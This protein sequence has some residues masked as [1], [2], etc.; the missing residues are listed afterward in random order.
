MTRL[1]AADSLPETGP[2]FVRGLALAYYGAALLLVGLLVRHAA[3]R[4]P[5]LAEVWRSGIAALALSSLLIAFA[6]LAGVWV[7]ARARVRS[8][9]TVG[10]TARLAQAVV[11]APLAGIASVLCWTWRLP[12]IMPIAPP[13]V[14]FAIGG[15]AI[16]LAFPL[17]IAER[18]VA[19]Q[20]DSVLPEAAALRALLLAPVLAWPLLGAL[21]IATGLGL[22]YTATATR[23]LA[24]VL[25]LIAAELAARALLRLFL[26]PP[27]PETARAAVRSTL[28]GIL[29]ASA[30][31]DGLAAPIRAHLG[32]D[33]ARSW[34]L[35]YVRAALPAVALLLL[36]LAWGLSGV[37]LVG[38]DQRAVYERFGAPVA[39]L[40]P[41]AHLILPWP[42]GTPRWTDFGAI[43]D[44]ALGGSDMPAAPERVGAEAFPPASAD[45][46]WT[47]AHPGEVMLLIA[48]ARG[49]QTDQQAFQ[50]VSLDLR[51][52][53]RVGMT[54]ADAIRAAYRVSDPQALVRG[55]A[56]RASAGFFASRTLA[57]VLGENRAT[58]AAGLRAAIQHSLDGFDSGI[59]VVAVVIEAIHP[60]SGAAD[61][62]HAVQAAEIDANASIANE[63]GRAQ[64]TKAMALQTVRDLVNGALAQ[65]ADADSRAQAER[66]RFEADRAADKANGQ[67]FMLERYFTALTGALAKVPLTILDHRIDPGDAPV[68]D[69]RPPTVAPP[70][71]GPNGE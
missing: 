43:H 49:G 6:G 16:V 53:W 21:E 19:V 8:P 13:P 4:A 38:V 35:A 69:V 31:G 11:V 3:F 46:L 5:W 37:V 1:T 64:G 40:R 61:A 42:L 68:L 27:S 15:A 12:E 56:G 20:S 32:I 18:S 26:P 44:V 47:Q 55:A 30:R 70:A 57:D 62:Y 41:G 71:S 29:S 14:C 23:V 9:H 67:S 59:E 45:R 52:L 33:F 50:A 28:A 24:V 36:A 51:V 39:V 66:A 25:A 48:S 22:P 63:R 65:A 54:D 17:L 34:A 58:M 60:P 2:R 7:Q 10:Q